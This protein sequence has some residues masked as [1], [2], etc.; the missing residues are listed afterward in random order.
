MTRKVLKYRKSITPIISN[1]PKE[2]FL[3]DLIDMKNYSRKNKGYKYVLNAIDHFS[4]K[5][6]SFPIKSRNTFEIYSKLQ[7]L[8]KTDCPKT[9]R[10]DNEFGSAELKSLYDNFNIKFKPSES[11]APYTNGCIERFNA[12]LKN[13][14]YRALELY[15]TKTYEDILPFLLDNYN[16][17]KH[18]SHKFTPNEVYK[19]DSSITYQALQNLQKYRLKK[20][21]HKG[22]ENIIKKGSTVKVSAHSNPNE[23]K[24]RLNFEK[25]FNKQW[26]NKNYIVEKVIPPR[27]I[28][29]NYLY[30]LEG[31]KKLYQRHE[32]LIVSPNENEN[33]PKKPIFN[34]KYEEKQEDKKEIKKEQKIKI[35]LT[36]VS[37]K[38]YGLNKM[39][40]RP[41]KKYNKYKDYVT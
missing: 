3:I 23:R 7:E 4:K 27:R 16:N 9:L 20:I 30:K 39:K 37:E 24:L 36:S 17:T 28:T 38:S 35:G 13:M 14:I 40:L 8:F 26:L 34:N 12:T 31:V 22:T 33:H 32:L 25:S 18:S 29:D 10:S 5:A 41:R 1:Y 2:L 11:Y 6:W 15:Q 21:Y 19:G